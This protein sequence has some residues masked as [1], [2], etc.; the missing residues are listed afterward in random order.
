MAETHIDFYFDPI[1]P[2]CWITSRW[3][4][5][6]APQRDVDLSWRPFSLLEKNYA[7]AGG[8]GD[9]EYRHR[10]ETTHRM[11]RMLEAARGSYGDGVVDALYLEL[12]RRFH[13][14]RDRDPDL[15]DVVVATG[16]PSDLVEAADDPD[17]DAAI[18]SSM[19]RAIE[20]AGHDVG[21]PLMVFDDERGFFG[22]VLSPRPTGAAALE[23]FDAV[24]T[25]ARQPGFWELKRDRDGRPELGERP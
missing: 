18:R 11:L 15:S 17:W 4:R 5:E 3:L 13:H 6:V 19:G 9:A 21:V 10:Y 16:L 22:P 23:L 12:G 8:H 14:D 1:C 7:M 20:I 2:W 24:A 25:L